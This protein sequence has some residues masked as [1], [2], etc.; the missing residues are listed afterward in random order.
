MPT[1]RPVLQERVFVAV[2]R[3]LIPALVSVVSRVP[4]HLIAV[5]PGKYT[6]ILLT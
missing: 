4:R 5:L 1:C 2:F 6:A 3:N